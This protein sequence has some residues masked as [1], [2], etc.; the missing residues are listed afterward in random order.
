MGQTLCPIFSQ[1]SRYSLSVIGLFFN[2]KDKGPLG[3]PKAFSS[4]IVCREVKLRVGN[5]LR[6][7]RD[8]NIHSRPAKSRSCGIFIVYVHYST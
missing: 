5:R 3:L 8:Q 7:I 1:C 2:H 6:E 4:D